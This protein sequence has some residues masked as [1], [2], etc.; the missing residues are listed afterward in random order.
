MNA[1]IIE[2]YIAKPVSLKFFLY[3]LIIVTITAKNSAAKQ[4]YP[5]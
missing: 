3:K 1:K 4:K 5:I 2:K